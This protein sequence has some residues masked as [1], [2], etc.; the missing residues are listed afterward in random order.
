MTP[1]IVD[2][3]F[4][5][6]R[7]DDAAV[8][9]AFRLSDAGYEAYV[10]GGAVRDLLL[11]QTPKDFDVATSATPEQVHRLF[12]GSRIIGRRFQ[13]VHVRMGREMIEVTTFR[14]HHDDV[15]PGNR[16]SS[17]Q[18]QSG[19]LLRDNVFGTLEQDAIRRDLTVNALYYDPVADTVIDYT[20]GLE[21]IASKQ[22]RIIG[23]PETRYREDPVRMLRVMRFKA[24]LQFNIDAET[25]AAIAT[26]SHLLA[27]IPAARLFD[28]FLKGFMSGHARALAKELQAT[29]LW[30]ELFPDNAQYAQALPS[31]ERLL[32]TA[33]ANTDKRIALEQPVTPAFLLAAILWPAVDQKASYWIGLGEPPIPAIADAGQAV[34]LSAIV[35]VAIP[36]RFSLIMREIWDLQTRFER[37]SKRKPLEFATHKRFRAAYDFLLLRAQSGEPVQELAD[38]WTRFQEQHPE[39]DALRHQA[40]PPE[41]PK[42]RRPRR[43]S[44]RK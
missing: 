35:R 22:L 36:K 25:D 6:D 27:Q 12:R 20:G 32:D 1:T 38:W 10:V 43:R 9:V 44:A 28:E 41:A 4:R 13:I 37:R 31:Y 3:T 18:G 39:L 21:D 19:V 23:D 29:P 2:R 17:Q 5:L 8:S 42:N 14:G 16:Q 26:C 30:E 33:L 34:I 24:K 11:N 40:N 15:L 7:L